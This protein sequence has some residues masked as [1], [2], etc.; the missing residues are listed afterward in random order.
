VESAL[1]AAIPNCVAIAFCVGKFFLGLS[2]A[3]CDYV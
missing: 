3:F 1:L 2:Y